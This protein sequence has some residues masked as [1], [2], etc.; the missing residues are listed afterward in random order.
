MKRRVMRS[1][2]NHSEIASALRVYGWQVLDIGWPADF[3][4]V[5]PGRPMILADAKSSAKAKFTESQLK[6]Q[7]QGFTLI[8]LNNIQD[9][10]RLSR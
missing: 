10:E 1:D 3:L 6:V 9:V 5:K 8:R 7:V 4:I 2:A